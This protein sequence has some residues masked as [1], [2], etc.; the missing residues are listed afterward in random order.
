MDSEEGMGG[1]RKG[2]GRERDLEGKR[3]RWEEQKGRRDREKGSK[4]NS[5]EEEMGKRR[6]V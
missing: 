2:G 5:E 1:G 3:E 6:R 4:A